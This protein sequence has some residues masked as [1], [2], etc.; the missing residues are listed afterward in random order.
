[1]LGVDEQRS[2]S[3]DLNCADETEICDNIVNWR[4]RDGGVVSGGADT[5][6][7]PVR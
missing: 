1:M 2:R 7:P 3:T 5:E 6:E 4:E